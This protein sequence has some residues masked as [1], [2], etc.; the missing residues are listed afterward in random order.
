MSKGVE[1]FSAYA[2]ASRKGLIP[3]MECAAQQTLDHPMTFEVVG[4][5]LRLFEGWALRDLVNFRRRCVDNLITCLG[6]YRVVEP[7]GPSSVWRGCP[8]NGSRRNMFLPRWLDQLLLQSQNDLRHQI[9]TNPLSIHSKIRGEYVRFLRTHLRCKFCL[10][11]HVT[12]S[13]FCTEL[14]NKLKQARYKVT[15]SFHLSTLRL[16]SCRYAVI[17]ALTSVQLTHFPGIGE[18]P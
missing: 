1:A 9:F 4:E 7:P 10:E 15:H 18:A 17:A 3:E 16:T 12:E 2:I 11:A 13:T 6:S 5:G 8:E 14:E